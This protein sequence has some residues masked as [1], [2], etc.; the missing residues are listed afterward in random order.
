[1]KNPH[2]AR[3]STNATVESVTPSKTQPV[4][5][6]IGLVGGLGVGAAIHYYR[7]LAAAHDD[8][9]RPLRLVMDHASISR[10]TEYASKGDRHGLAVYLAGFLSRLKSAGATFGVIPAV[11]PHLCIDELKRITPLPV[12]DITE[13]VASAVRER[14]LSKVALFGTRFVIESDL[15]GRLA[16]VD[17]V[18]P[19]PDEVEFVHRAYTHLAHSATVSDDD[20]RQLTDLAG[21][22]EKR[23]GVDA[24]LLAGTDFALMFDA[25]NTSFPHLDCA[26][27]HIDAILRAAGT[28]AA[29]PAIV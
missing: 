4:D 10:A 23:E 6:L 15:Y 22:L 27:I 18:R 7:A 28:T 2:W 11:T 5:T 29:A 16:G 26:R 24:I 13:A 12:I 8:R 19:R 25:S 9:L 21:T 1:M 3:R 14:K 17:V 20:R